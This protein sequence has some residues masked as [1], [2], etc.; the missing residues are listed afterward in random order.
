ME[1][2]LFASPKHPDQIWG[3]PSLIF[4]GYSGALFLG[5]KHPGH[6]DFKHEWSYTSAPLYAFRV[7]TGTVLTLHFT[8]FTTYH[9]VICNLVKYAT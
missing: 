7:C 3:P 2:R 8:V 5:V 4:S 6:D 1:K 9:S